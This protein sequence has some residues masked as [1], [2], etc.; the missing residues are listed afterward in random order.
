MQ[1]SDTTIQLQLQ[2]AN[3]VD[4]LLQ[5][6]RTGQ[7]LHAK[8]LSATRNGTLQVQ[9]GQTVLTAQSN[10]SIPT[11]TKLILSVSQ[12]GELPQLNILPTITPKQLLQQAAINTLPQQ[13]PLQPLLQN[14]AA[15]LA[16]GNPLPPPFKALVTN[17]IKSILTSSDLGT[18]QNLK[19]AINRSGPFLEA[20]LVNGKAPKQDLKATLIKLVQ[21]LKPLLEQSGQMQSGKIITPTTT[22]SQTQP[23][24]ATAVTTRLTAVV[25]TGVTTGVTTAIPAATSNTVA[26]EGQT[27]LTIKGALPVSGKQPQVAIPTGRAEAPSPNPL[28]Q[29][30]VDL[31]K[32]LEG[33]IARVQMHQLTSLQSEEG[34]KTVWQLELPI[35]HADQTN[36]F[37]IHIERQKEGSSGNDASHAWALTVK[38]DLKPLGPMQANLTLKKS[39]ELSTIFW[40]KEQQ[41]LSLLNKNLPL[42]RNNLERAGLN[43]G[44]IEAYHGEPPKAAQPTWQSTLLDEKA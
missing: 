18:N 20:Q 13:Q 1:I 29:Q 12:G 40:A 23:L 22:P 28:L 17:F 3:K 2:I 26:L 31:F 21:M 5:N 27:I 25:P 4:N 9:I 42:L 7:I 24:T 10:I 15:L 8:T 41:T 11:G 16:S 6:L 33:A 34:N 38:F 35:R 36:T 43:I 37:D 32:S 19:E 39:N 14:L 30:L 44:R